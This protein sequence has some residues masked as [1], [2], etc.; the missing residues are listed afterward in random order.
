MALVVG[1]GVIVVLAVAMVV[2]VAVE[3]GPSP[4]DVAVSYEEAWERLDFDTLWVLSGRELRDRLDRKAFVA[5]KRDAYGDSNELAGL[6]S[7]VIVDEIAVGSADATVITR[8]ELRD[9]TT[10]RDEVR[11]LRRN[12]RWEVAGYSLH[13]PRVSS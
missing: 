11:M 4:A 9:G 3:R 13:R 1:I 6:A 8:L 2:M 7:K 10:L 12:G 5:A